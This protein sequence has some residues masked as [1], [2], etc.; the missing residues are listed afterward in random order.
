MSYG[1]FFD[2]SKFKRTSLFLILQFFLAACHLFSLTSKYSPQNPLPNIL[3]TYFA[4]VWDNKIPALQH[5]KCSNTRSFLWS[6]LCVYRWKTGRSYTLNGNEHSP[7]SVY[8]SRYIDISM[9]ITIIARWRFINRSKRCLHI[10]RP[11]SILNFR[12]NLSNDF[13]MPENLYFKFIFQ[14]QERC[15]CVSVPLVNVFCE[16]LWAL[17]RNMD[18]I[19]NETFFRVIYLKMPMTVAA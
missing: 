17:C 10:A 9:N 1:I 12:W 19:S 8:S 15:I 6:S 11:G 16:A 14:R 13:A 2:V 4:T 18:S 7:N 5:N 3:N